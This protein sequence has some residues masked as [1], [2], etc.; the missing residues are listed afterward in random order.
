MQTVELFCGTKSFSKVAA[1]FGHSTFTLDNDPRHKPDLCINVL[2]LEASTLPF[3]PD[4][5]WASPPCTTF[6]IASHCHHWNVDGT[7]KSEAALVGIKIARKTLS[8]IRDIAPRWWFI[9]NPRGMLRR[10]PFMQGMHR[11][12]I[13]YCQYGHRIMKPTDIWTNARWWTPRPMCSP[14]DPCHEST[15]AGERTGLQ[16]IRGTVE[17]S[18]IPRQL[19]LE[20]LFQ[21][22]STATRVDGVA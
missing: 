3:R 2:A 4:I 16:G 15:R 12:T 19:F 9:E 10:M 18:R 8:L 1:H 17:R 22:P 6:S 14:G 5:L 13:T 7:P 21:M 20:I 11:N